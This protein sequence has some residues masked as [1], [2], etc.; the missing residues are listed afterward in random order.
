MNV[1]LLVHSPERAQSAQ[2][3]CWSAHG[4]AASVAEAFGTSSKM[5]GN[6]LEA[7]A[8]FSEVAGSVSDEAEM[9]LEAVAVSA[10]LVPYSVAR[11]QDH[12]HVVFMKLGLRT[13]SPVS[14][15]E[16]QFTC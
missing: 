14:T 16:V 9:E 8:A 1:G 4:F 3:S 6:S 15:H 5:S 10:A 12:A 2:C 7:S 11:L 13:H